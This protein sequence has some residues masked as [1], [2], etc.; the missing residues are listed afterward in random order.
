MLQERSTPSLVQFLLVAV[1]IVAV[2]IFAIISMNTGD[3]LWFWP[4]FN[5]TSHRMVLHCYG[6]DIVVEPGDPAYET[7]NAAVNDSLSGT[8]RWDSLSMSDATYDEYHTSSEMMVLELGY[9]PPERL[10]SFYKFFKSFD[11]LVIPLDGRHASFDTVFGRFR[12]NTLAGS[13]HVED[14]T[15]IMTTLADQDLCNKP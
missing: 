5:G 14:T 8:K 13:F 7:V 10:H 1:V 11:T 2:I 6:Q 4:I 3:I 15:K 9:D 12:T